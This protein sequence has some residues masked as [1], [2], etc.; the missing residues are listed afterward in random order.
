LKDKLREMI[1][2]YIID[3]DY[4][5][6]KPNVKEVEEFGYET[7]RIL[8]KDKF[9]DKAKRMIHKALPKAAAFYSELATGSG[10]EMDILGNE[11]QE[12]EE[13]V[14]ESTGKYWVIL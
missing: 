14:D 2:D 8:S 5:L 11:E 9:Y 4:N 6:I 10:W 7:A 12:D 1:F 3:P 13:M